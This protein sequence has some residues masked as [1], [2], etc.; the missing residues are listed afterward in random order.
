MGIEVDVMQAFCDE[1]RGGNPAGVVLDADGLTAVQKLQVARTMG[2]SETA[3]VSRSAVASI[4]LEFFT[5]A[6]QIAHCGHATVAALALCEQRRRLGD[7]LHT[8]ESMDGS[9]LQAQL[10]AGQV[11]MAQP[12]PHFRP[13]AAG[14]DLALCALQSVAAAPDQ[15]RQGGVMQVARS[16]NAF[17]LIPMASPEALA[18]LQPDDA[19]IAAVCE[20]LDLVGFY[21]YATP[22]SQPSRAATTRMFAPRFGIREESATGTAA[23]P[24]GAWLMAEAV[25]AGPCLIEQGHWMRSAA[26]SLITVRR[27][28]PAADGAA[29]VLVSGSAVRVRSV[30]LSV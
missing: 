13:L 25:A 11:T 20:Q 7:G 1:G 22:A 16:G 26:P 29:Q 9:V 8:H 21:P 14:S 17:L 15:L 3:F 19:Q 6:R 30:R 23:G 10:Q 27:S 24:L 28:A 12:W 5:P 18:A 4:K 2:L